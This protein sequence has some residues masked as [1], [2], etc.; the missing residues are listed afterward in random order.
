[1]EIRQNRLVCWALWLNTQ[2]KSTEP[3]N[4]PPSPSCN[5]ISR[6]SGHPV[7]GGLPQPLVQALRVQQPRLFGEL[8]VL[9]AARVRPGPG[10]RLERR[11]RLRAELRRRLQQLGGRED[12]QRPHHRLQRRQL[13]PARLL[14][15]RQGG[16]SIEHIFACVL[17][18]L[19]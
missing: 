15:N 17:A 18:V 9:G 10:V 11:G 19:A 14:G 1:M 16:N 3:S 7:A 4:Q 8:G 12:P 13:G 2:T 6:S 5:N